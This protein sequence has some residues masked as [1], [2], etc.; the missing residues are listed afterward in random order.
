MVFERIERVAIAVRDFD[1][2]E[3]FFSDL[4]DMEFDEPGYNTESKVKAA[5]SAFGLELIGATEPDSLVDNFIKKRGEGVF[6]VV[7]KVKNLD[8]AIEIFEQKGLRR[9][10]EINQGGLR[11]VLFHPKDSYGVQLVLAE[12]KAMHPASVAAGITGETKVSK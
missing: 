11:E 2:A 9:V 4:L 7:I 1:E 6:C 8:K 3:K 10:G 12:Y 5:Y